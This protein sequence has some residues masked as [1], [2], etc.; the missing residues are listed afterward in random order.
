M[1]MKLT[2]IAL[3]AGVLLLGGAATAYRGTANA[4]APQANAT[5]ATPTAVSLVNPSFESTT[6]IGDA[7]T[8][9]ADGLRGYTV[10]SIEGWTLTDTKESDLVKLFVTAEAYSDNN[11][12]KITSIPNGTY[13]LYLRRGWN[14]GTTTLSQ[15][16]SSLPSGEYSLKFKWRSGY[17]NNATSSFSVIAGSKESSTMQFKQGSANF[18]TT[19]PWQEF[20]MTFNQATDG[21]AAIKLIIDWLSGGSCLMLDDFSLTRIGDVTDPEGPTVIDSPTEGKITHEFVT[22]PQM[23]DDLLQMLADFTPYMKN[24]WQA[25]S[26]NN[27]AGSPL[28]VFKGENTMGNNEHGVRHNADFSMI[29]AFLVKYAQGK[30]T[31]PAGITWDNLKDW[32]ARSLNYAYSTHKANKLYACKGNSY[33]GSTS[34]ND[35]QWESSLW[36]MSVAY[37]AFFQ[38]DTL[39]DAQK[40]AIEKLLEAECNYELQRNI[41]T[42]YNGD[43]KAEENGWEADVLAVAL[44]LFPNNAKAQAWFERMREFAINSYSH[45]DDATNN[46]V[47]D[48]DYDNKTVA[49]LYKGQNLYEDWTLQNHNLFHTSY[50]NVVMQE[51]GE[52]ALGLKLFQKEL[53]GTEKWKS[54]ALMHNNQKVMDNVLNRLALAD[55]ELAMPNGNDWSLFLFDQI[56]SYSTMACFLQ[57]PVALFLENMAYKYIKARQKTTSDGSWLLRADVGSRRMGVEAHR[58]MMTWLMH[59]VMPTQSVTPATW[60]QIYDKYGETYIFPSQNVVRS[61]SPSRFVCFSWS[62]GLQNYSGYI[63]SNNPDNNKIIVPFRSGNNGNFLGWYEVNDKSANATPVVSGIYETGKHHFVMNGELNT[64]G[65]T[66]NNRFVIYSTPGNAVIYLDYVTANSEA[67]ISKEKG[68]LMAISTDPFTKE[69]RTLYYEGNE[70]GNIT[71]GKTFVN[72]PSEWANIDGQLGFVALGNKGMGFGDQSNNN[73]ILTSK[74]YTLYYD[75]SRTVKA[76]DVVDR[77]NVNYYTSVDVATT[78]TMRQKTLPLTDKLPQGWNGVVVPDPDGVYYLLVTNFLSMD[79]VELTGIN[80][81]GKAPVFSVT[82]K[83]KDNESSAT[84]VEQLNNSLANELRVFVKGTNLTA[85]QD[86]D[87]PTVAYITNNST[88]ASPAVTIIAD[89]TPV[90]GDVNIPAGQTVKVYVQNGAIKYEAATF[91][92]IET[93]DLT[94]GYTDITASHLS[95]PG[96]EADES[97]STNSSGKVDAGTFTDCF[98]NTVPYINE[99]FENVLPVKDWTNG[100][101]LDGDSPWCRMYS[102]PYSTTKFCVS[103]IGNYA[104]KCAPIVGDEGVGKRCLTVLSSWA[105]GDNRIYKDINLEPGDYRVLINMK[106]ECPNAG[107]NDGHVIKCG[108]NTNTSLTGVKIG[109]TTDYRYA[110]EMNQWETLAYDFTLTESKPVQISLGYN[111]NNGAGAANNTLLYLDNVRILKKIGSGIEEIVVDK[112]STAV[113]TLDG[114]LV[115][116]AGDNSPLPAGTYVTKGHKFIVR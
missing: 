102:M 116:R 96:F 22:E 16:I 23:K 87:D 86:A 49:D 33:W 77:R 48:P 4:P 80:I 25:I 70:A 74:L 45:P 94:Q 10:N 26:S 24:N 21:P 39:T 52:A 42:G 65:G 31:L 61:S 71:N 59:E 109:N 85:V 106:V 84:V 76:G 101:T 107:S 47:I 62:S 53:T 13:A 12:G 82:T 99:K 30:V 15:E 110:K 5:A 14:A 38:W 97:Y 17:A 79:A 32:A 9:N 7:V 81:E 51:L 63:A 54:N 67:T 92:V 105:K 44:G 3:T 104:A 114:I 111:I 73:S 90:S 46:T 100:M 78:K 29:C 19:E 88:A 108:T 34:K 50:Q 11:F 75:K 113:Y 40:S 1:I 103:E 69:K 72:M 98:V 115:R 64:N 37:S 60:Q 91:P 56:T 6:G 83:I 8:N 41:P 55:G 93:E 95:N 2:Y 20:S 66:L 35:N 27:S 18:F 58:V 28:G 43:T 57:D 36:A 89:G 112:A 68:G